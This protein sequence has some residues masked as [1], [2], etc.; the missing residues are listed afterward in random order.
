[1][2]KILYADTEKQPDESL[3]AVDGVTAGGPR[4]VMLKHFK[5]LN[6]SIAVKKTLAR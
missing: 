6:Y 5:L 2:Q 1:M 3:C 4:F